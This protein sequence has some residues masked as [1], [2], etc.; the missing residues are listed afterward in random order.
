LQS[1]ELERSSPCSIT[2]GI[3]C[4]EGH[5]GRGGPG[6]P[7]RGDPAP[8]GRRPG[9]THRAAGYGAAEGWQLAG[10]RPG[11]V[12]VSLAAAIALGATSVIA[13]N[14]A[15][16][17]AAWTRLLGLH[18]DADLREANP[19][20]LRPGSGT[21]PPGSPATPASAPSRSA[22]TGPGRTRSSPAGTG[23]APCPH[24]PDR[25]EPPRQRERRT[26]PAPSEPV[27]PRAPRAP[28]PALPPAAN[29][30]QTRNR[31][32]HNQ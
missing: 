6:R 2:G 4:P 28:P 7:R 17:L 19:G 10:L 29:R 18:D 16:D 1:L 24:P 32:Q 27:R 20:T 5:R 3:T 15:A 12:L 8:Q 30:H 25:H 21:S 14:I 31:R 26:T 13:A 23:C 22:P 11:V 9:G